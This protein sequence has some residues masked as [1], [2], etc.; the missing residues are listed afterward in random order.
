MR[1][2]LT[3]IFLFSTI[4]CWGQ[5]FS[6]PSC[7]KLKKF[8]KE[9][10]QY[11][12]KK[13][14]C[15]NG[16]TWEID[17]SPNGKALSAFLVENG[18]DPGADPIVGKIY[19]IKGR[20]FILSREE[21]RHG[22]SALLYNVYNSWCPESFKA[23]F[24]CI[25]CD[26][27]GARVPHTSQEVR[28]KDV[29]DNTMETIYSPSL[30]DTMYNGEM[31]SLKCD[32]TY[33]FTSKNL[34][35][36]KYIITNDTIRIKCDTII[37]K[38]DTIMYRDSIIDRCITAKN[39]FSQ[40][41]GIFVEGGV[42]FSKNNVFNF[43]LWR[44]DIGFKKPIIHGLFNKSKL[45]LGEALEITGFIRKTP[46]DFVE[47]ACGCNNI[48][49]RTP[50]SYGARGLYVLSLLSESRFRPSIGIGAEYTYNGLTRESE[51]TV[52]KTSIVGVINPRL[53]ILVNKNIQVHLGANV[54]VP[55]N[56]FGERWDQY[57]SLRWTLSKSNAKAED[58]K[59]K[60]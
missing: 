21:A 53:E 20:C 6:Q 9:D 56:L 33:I 10:L 55:T 32:S 38:K 15:A 52:K 48:P 35:D 49:Q 24:S 37:I 34:V 5:E 1:Q 14:F 58:K 50:I 45:C 11:V 23:A 31:I 29:V 4:L 12:G 36:G 51:I 2:I 22:L 46:F 39:L 42:G 16:S 17:R 57:V 7:E 28:C 19:K 26:Q 54:Y 27:D 8:T 3:F 60:S 13:G 25:K 41:K 44:L 18:I 30:I 40:E 43:P 59:K 47:D